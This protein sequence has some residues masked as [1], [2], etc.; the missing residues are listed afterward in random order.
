M[1]KILIC[2][3]C[4]VALSLWSA[5]AQSRERIPLAAP[6]GVV[7]TADNNGQITV[8][9][10]AV[11]RA[12]TYFV[13]YA[14]APILVNEQGYYHTVGRNS[15]GQAPGYYRWYYVRTTGTSATLTEAI[16]KGN[17]R[18]YHIRVKAEPPNVLNNPYTDSPLS[19]EVSALIP[20]MAA[21]TN[22]RVIAGND[23]ITVSW[24]PVSHA[25]SYVVYYSQRPLPVRNRGREF[26]PERVFGGFNSNSTT[27]TSITIT[28]RIRTNS[29]RYYVRVV[30]YPEGSGYYPGWVSDQASTTVEGPTTDG[31]TTTDGGDPEPLPPEPEPTPPEP[32][33]TPP[34]PE[35]TP[36]P[37]PDRHTNIFFA[38]GVGNSPADAEASRALLEARYGFFFNSSKSSKKYPG[39][40]SF[41]TAYNPTFGTPA[42][43][44][45]VLVQKWNEIGALAANPDVQKLQ[46]YLL[47]RILDYWIARA[48]RGDP[49]AAGRVRE[50]MERIKPPL[51]NATIDA[52]TPSVLDELAKTLRQQRIEG[53]QIDGSRLGTSA[54]HAGQY[55]ISLRR[56]NRVFVVS[57]SQGNLFTN[58]ALQAVARALHACEPSLEQIGVA[59]PAN[60]QFRPFYRTG[61][62]DNVINGLR[63]ARSRLRREGV[64]LGRV[65]KA[66]ID[67]S[68]GRL[69]LAQNHAFIGEYMKVTHPSFTQI[70]RQMKSIARN[71]PFPPP[72]C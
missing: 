34:P 58:V 60:V 48:R 8:N 65:L 9:W 5:L 31:G 29:N 30:A 32:E 35:P 13:M 6:T 14:R 22:V 12:G 7:A 10:T 55:S 20:R 57:H 28:D 50:L 61:I 51:T 52:F 71:T 56:G 25:N 68:G 49:A 42:D 40:Y 24:A 1:K 18:R 3:A 33:P 72:G 63:L 62:D 36:K 39:T 11:D 44:G 38:N 43:V 15:P 21:P 2:A 59:T 46:G 26:P 16:R 45:E 70:D 17:G 54:S 23:Q 53:L 4:V 19:A 27:G 64:L 37:K 67:N 47:R 66:N 41:H 69:R